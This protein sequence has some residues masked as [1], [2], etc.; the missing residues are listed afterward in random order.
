MIHIIIHNGV[1]S[2]LK[3]ICCLF[4]ALMYYTVFMNWVCNQEWV[5]FGAGRQDRLFISEAAEHVCM[6]AAP[7]STIEPLHTLGRFH[8]QHDGTCASD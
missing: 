6:L 8:T 7:A 2:Y 4:S 1:K 5:I 3:D